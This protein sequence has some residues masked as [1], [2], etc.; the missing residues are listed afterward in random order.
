MVQLVFGAS[1]FPAGGRYL[2]KRLLK[3]KRRALCEPDLLLDVVQQLLVHPSKS[4][5]G[6]VVH[7]LVNIHWL[8]LTQH[9]AWVESFIYLLVQVMH[10]LVLEVE[11]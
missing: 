10:H 1:R 6:L 11:A 4:L 2:S 7:K 3:R 9:L 5:L 8:D